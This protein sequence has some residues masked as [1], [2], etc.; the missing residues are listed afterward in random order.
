MLVQKRILQI[1]SPSLFRGRI[2]SIFDRKLE[3]FQPHSE[4]FLIVFQM[5]FI[6]DVHEEAP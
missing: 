6:R 4:L 1:S 3:Y 5:I 2:L